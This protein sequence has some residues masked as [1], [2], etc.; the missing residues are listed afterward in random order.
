[1]R[2]GETDFKELPP[3]IV[4]SGKSEIHRASWQSG[5]LSRI[6]MLGLKQNSFFSRALLLLFLRTSVSWMDYTHIIKDILLYLKI[7]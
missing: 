2:I 7:N 6:F 1:M 5:N 4:E 3:M